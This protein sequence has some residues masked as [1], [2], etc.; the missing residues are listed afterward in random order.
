[1]AY[2]LLITDARMWLDY[3]EQADVLYVS[4]AVRESHR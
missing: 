2:D 4:F 3:D 1:M